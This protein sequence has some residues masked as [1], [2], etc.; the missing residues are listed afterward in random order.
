MKRKI[1]NLSAPI[2]RGVGV[3]VIS[4]VLY[5]TIVVI[6]TPSLRPVDAISVSVALNWWL[7]GGISLGTG[8]QA[9]LLAYAKATACTIKHRAA[10]VGTSG[11]LS[12]LS[13][14][15]SFLSLIPLGCC[16]TWVYILSFLPGLIGAGA[17]GFLIDNG[18]QLEL[19]G[20]GLMAFSVSYTYL[21][22]KKKLVPKRP[23]SI[24]S[25][26]GQAD[27]PSRS[28]RY[29]TPLLVVII[30][31]IGLALLYSGYEANTPPQLLK[32]AFATYSGTIVVAGLGSVNANRTYQVIDFNGTSAE[33][34]M[35]TYFGQVRLQTTSWEPYSA[36]HR[37]HL[38]GEA[39]VKEYYAIQVP[40]GKTYRNLI[41]EEYVQGNLTT[42]YY[43]VSNIAQF[44]IEIVSKGS[45]NIQLTLAIT[46][47]RG[48]M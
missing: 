10:A 1:L 48:L 16:G 26:E 45:L 12:G 6:T 20:L 9:F 42:I 14:F 38:A 5:L 36:H 27:P 4:V 2:Q 37:L 23:R 15:V 43:Y 22:V 46:N 21:S 30:A 11:I 3:S 29:S 40:V 32:G 31:A 39:F 44:P 17:S 7:I 8:V 25:N 41:A 28:V 33:L 34:S 18:F 13:S 19:A 35:T 24:A 47:M